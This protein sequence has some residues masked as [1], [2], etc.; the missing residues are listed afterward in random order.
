MKKNQ[1][2][3]KPLYLSIVNNQ[4]FSYIWNPNNSQWEKS[5]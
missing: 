1:D 3:F 5:D 4:D 2:F